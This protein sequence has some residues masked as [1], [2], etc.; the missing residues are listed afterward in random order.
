MYCVLHPEGVQISLKAAEDNFLCNDYINAASAILS[1]VTK[2]L[3]FVQGYIS[4][5]EDVIYRLD[6]RETL[7]Q[8]FLY[9]DAI[10]KNL[11]Y[12]MDMFETNIFTAFQGYLRGALREY[13]AQLQREVDDRYPHDLPYYH[14]Y[15]TEQMDIIDAIRAARNF[16]EFVPLAHRYLYLRKQLA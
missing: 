16:D 13:Y 6:V 11:Q 10:K 15:V 8:R 12:S 9:V 2:D 7:R 4:R 1:R 3:L 5:G 14:H